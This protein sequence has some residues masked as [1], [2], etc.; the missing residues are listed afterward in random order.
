MTFV[1]S[2]LGL[3]AN[4]CL[5]RE[6]PERMPTFGPFVVAVVLL[7]IGV[8]TANVVVQLPHAGFGVALGATLVAIATVAAC[9]W[10]LLIA[11]GT[12][13]RFAATIT[14][15]LGCDALTTA[16]Q[17]MLAPLAGLLPDLVQVVVPMLLIFWYLA[18]FGFVL[19]R[20]LDVSVWVGVLIAFGVILISDTLM[21]LASPGLLPPPQSA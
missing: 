3:F 2:I 8:E 10:A 11:H 21:L 17:L 5:L 18:I 9:T 12:P 7:T 14:A 15:V 4:I 19:H 16:V 6:G 20:A 1:R 13:G